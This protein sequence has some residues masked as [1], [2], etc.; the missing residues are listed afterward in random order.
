MLAEP[1]Q[2]FSY[3]CKHQLTVTHHALLQSTSC[4]ELYLHRRSCGV[5]GRLCGA[6]F[7]CKS[8][9]AQRWQQLHVLLINCWRVID[10]ELSVEKDCHTLSY[11]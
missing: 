3:G 11:L 2:L 7:A 9:A 1:A 10:V 5:A 6:A 8:A 4:E